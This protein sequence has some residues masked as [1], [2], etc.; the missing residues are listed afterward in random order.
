MGA[1]KARPEP[2]RRCSSAF[3][4]PTSTSKRP[5]A[6]A[7]YDQSVHLHEY[8]SYD[9]LGL[10]ELVRHGAVTPAELAALAIEAAERLNPHLNAVVATYPESVAEASAGSGGAFAGV[11]TLLKDLFHGEPGWECGNGSRLCHG[12]TVTQADAF[13]TRLRASGLVPVGRSATSEF[14]LL[15]TTETLA[16]GRTASPWN[17]NVMAGGSSGGAGSAVGAGIVPVAGASDG[18][19]SIRIPASACGVVGLKPSRGRVSWG[20][21]VGEPLMGWAVHF[22]LSR[23]V[24]DTAAALDALSGPEVG[25]PFEIAGPSR[26]FMQEV[27]APVEPLRVAVWAQPWSGHPGDAETA[28]ATTATARLLAEAGHRVEEARPDFAWEQFLQAMTDL[29]SSTSAHSIDGLAAALGRNVDADTLEGPTLAMVEHGRR[30]SAQRLLDGVEVVNRLARQVGEF[31]ERYDVLLTPT[32]GSLP[33][34][35]GEYDATAP[36]QPGET[37]AAW[38][39][40]ESFLPVFN[41]TGQ[42]AISLPLHHSTAGLPIGIQLVGRTGSEARLLRLSAWLE[43]AAPWAGR[44]PLWHAAGPLP[45]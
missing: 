3:A 6:K 2:R 9:G 13:T 14:G 44:M 45:A 38:S 7:S 5:R 12:W 27:G 18:G 32:L 19:G 17:I 40:L 23:S 43:Q 25:D 20:P 15:G 10:A 30:V 37:F 8:A 41:A 26:P 22:V 28:S 35:L 4:A 42:P 16:A 31:F 29:W 1:D 33:A 11:P 24:R 39:H 34:S 36:T 21:L